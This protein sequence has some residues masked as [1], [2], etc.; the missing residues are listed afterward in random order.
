MKLKDLKPNE[1][2]VINSRKEAKQ[3]RKLLKDENIFHWHF[4]DDLDLSKAILN[5]YISIGS[6]LFTYNKE[7]A[8]FVK[9]YKVKDFLPKK[10]KFKKD[11]NQELERLDNEVHD[12]KLFVNTFNTLIPE[13]LK[14]ITEPATP[15]KLEVGKWYKDRYSK[16]LVYI[17]EIHRFNN[18]ISG[19]GF[20]TNLSWFESKRVS[21]KDIIF[22]TATHEEVETALIEE[23]KRRGFKEIAYF[24][25]YEKTNVL[26]NQINDSEGIIVFDNGKWAEI[27]QE[28]KKEIDWHKSGQ[29]LFQD[30]HKYVVLTTGRHNDN[31]FEGILLD[32]S[33]HFSDDFKKEY[34]VLH[35]GSITLKND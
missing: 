17:Q 2:I 12:L 34:Y 10:S 19:Y 5:N 18:D 14:A 21:I 1:C 6:E 33:N 30:T 23:A 9:E 25:F 26:N 28:P 4:N 20:Y 13:T 32:G 24:R 29:L 31:Y 22:D 16:F 3:L 27:V 8:V 35:N 11:V 15:A 7:G